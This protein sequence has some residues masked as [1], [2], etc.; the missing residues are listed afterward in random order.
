MKNDKTGAGAVAAGIASAPEEAALI[1]QCVL[2]NGKNGTDAPALA[3]SIILYAVNMNA[4]T[5]FLPSV[6]T[7]IGNLSFK[8]AKSLKFVS[9]RG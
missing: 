8:T 4:A 5:A 9:Q 2:F 6:V 3:G 7:E 1:G